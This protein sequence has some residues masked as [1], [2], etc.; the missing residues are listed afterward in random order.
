MEWRSSSTLYF[1][2][3]RSSCVLQSSPLICAHLHLMQLIKMQQIADLHTLVC[4]CMPP[5]GTHCRQDVLMDILG[6]PWKGGA[7]LPLWG[8]STGHSCCRQEGGPGFP[9]LTPETAPAIFVLIF[10]SCLYLM[11]TSGS[12]NLPETLGK[13]IGFLSSVCNECTTSEAAAGGGE[14]HTHVLA[15]HF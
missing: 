8:G 9:A 3:E 6:F 4:N 15:K 10:P 7:F 14:A 5:S 13:G 1:F 12:L 2:L 11:C